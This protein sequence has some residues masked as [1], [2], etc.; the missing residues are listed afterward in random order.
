MSN[1]RKKIFVE[2]KGAKWLERILFANEG[3]ISDL[4]YTK[5]LIL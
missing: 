4:A 3:I 1:R 2:K 5:K